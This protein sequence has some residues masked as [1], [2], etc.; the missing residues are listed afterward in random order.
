[1]RSPVVPLSTAAVA[2]LLTTAACTAPTTS[3]VE[4][5]ASVPPG[6]PPDPK[7][8]GSPWETVF[9][10]W[11]S[12]VARVAS[13]GCDDTSAGSG[14]LVAQDTLVTAHHVVEDAAWISL[15][16]DTD[17]VSGTTVAVDVDADLAVVRLDGNVAARS[18]NLADE[19]AAVGAGVAALGYPH[20]EPLGMTQG[21]VAA[22]GLRVNVEGQDRWGLIRTDAALN[23]GNSGGPIVTVDGDVAGVAVAGT[24]APGDWYAVGLET[25]QQFLQQVD[26]GTATV[27]TAVTCESDWDWPTITAETV[28]S[29][30]SSDHPDAPSIAQ[31]IQLYAESV[32]TGSIGT[33]WTLLTP[34]MQ[35]RVGSIE[36]YAE[37]LSS[38]AWHSFDVEQVEVVDRT[39]DTAVVSFRTTQAA[40]HGPG[41][42]TCTD[43]RVTYTLALDAGFW[44]IDAAE[45]TDGLPAVPC[46]PG[47]DEYGD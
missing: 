38:S 27:P 18:L 1:M 25:L 13:T 14:F 9:A 37:G 24:S 17:V 5:V 45:L 10:T 41:G 6:P 39:T 16:F 29:A 11:S 30:V 22:T 43:W 21:A 35:E 19:S 40:E 46:E 20:G 15:R 28:L 36:E 32:N 47:W 8:E 34:R 33:V 44:Q 3:G 31:T 42:A 12:G 4:I 7:P 26:A 23:P 2:L